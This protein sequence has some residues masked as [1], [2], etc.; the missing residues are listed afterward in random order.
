MDEMFS[1]ALIGTVEIM[2]AQRTAEARLNNQGTLA[3][4]PGPLAPE[5]APA[6]G[7]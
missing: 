7:W 3:A 1:A 2:A 5:L 4:A 6:E